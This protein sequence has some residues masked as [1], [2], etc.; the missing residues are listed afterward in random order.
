MDKIKVKTP[1]EIKVMAEGGKKLARVKKAL[2]EKVKEGVS[3]AEIEALA[4]LEK[5][6]NEKVSPMCG[7]SVYNDR[8]FL[9][10]YMP[11][12]EAYFHYRNL[13]VSTLKILA[14]KFAPDL[15]KSINWNK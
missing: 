8:R 14:Q 7:N 11:K 5:Y 15:L 13:D 12:L 1:K 2:A 4:F 3:A 9:S 6:T 10:K